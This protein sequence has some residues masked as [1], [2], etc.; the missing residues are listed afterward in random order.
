MSKER[1]K[2]KK[3]PVVG[4]RG[5]KGGNRGSAL[6]L[7]PSP[8]SSRCPPSHGVSSESNVIR[9]KLKRVLPLKAKR[10]W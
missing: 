3:I 1:G 7:T 4:G 2:E 9:D 6:S 5:D 8:P 10:E